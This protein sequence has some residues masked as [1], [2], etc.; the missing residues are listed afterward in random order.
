MHHMYVQEKKDP[1]CQL[2][3]T[4]YRLTPKDICIIV[5]DSEEEWKITLEKIGHPEEEED[6][7][8]SDEEP[9]DQ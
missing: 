7:D 5:N 4:N 6:K 1:T 2:F 9:N 3:P 8:K